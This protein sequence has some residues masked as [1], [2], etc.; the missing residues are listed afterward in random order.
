[1]IGFKKRAIELLDEKLDS[2]SRE[3]VEN[4]MEIPPSYEM[5]DYAFPTFRLAKEY[6]K[7]PNAIAEEIAQSIGDDEYFERIQSQGPY[8]NFFIDRNKLAELVI[9]DVM[10]KK[11]RY[12]SSDMGE[13]KKVIVEFSS[14]NIAKPFHIGHIRTTVIGNS[15]AKIYEFLGF[16]TITINHLGDYGTQFGMLI[17]AYKKWGDREVI[18]ANPIP[19]LLKLYV[20]FNEEAEAD[21]DLKDEARYWFKELENKNP[22]ALELWKWIRDISLKEFNRVYD[23]LNIK[24]DS[25]AGE[26][27]YS[28]KMPEVL[29]EMKEKGIVEES[30][31]ALIVDLEEYGMPPALIMKKDGSTLYTTRDIAAALYRKKQYDFHKNLYVVASQQ[32]LHFKAWIK[33]VELMGHEWA[34]DCIHI[35]FG[36]VSLEEG[37]L[38]TRKG[39]V[40]FLEDVLNKAIE[41]TRNIIEERNPDLENK[42]LVAKQI[43]IGAILFQE[44]FNQRIKDYTFNW[45]RTLSF[46]GETGPY[47]QYTHARAN[48]LLEKG[49]FDPGDKISFDKLTGEDEINI[50]RMIY[51]FPGTILDAMEKNEPFYITRQIVEIAKAFNKFYNSTQ[52]ITDDEET[53]KARLALVYSTKTVI[54]T[55]L[56][57]LGIEAPNKM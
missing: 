2:L 45:D 43:G 13:G 30:E 44:L 47:V 42:D 11:D 27:F 15:L 39:R 54:K 1:M 46:E 4:L 35:P 51:D 49:G 16:D 50:I 41:S 7:A 18:E 52:I 20:R 25:Y 48:S 12:G 23:M 26:S 29:E 28:D 31:G 9:T 40:V 57:L 21:P 53:K 37:T 24:F 32:N 33:I 6:R 36:M 5:G 55:G 38:S 10:D 8:V 56:G 19:E 22:E 17:S 14:P 34:K 3:E